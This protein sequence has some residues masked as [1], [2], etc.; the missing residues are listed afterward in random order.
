[1]VKKKIG[2]LLFILSKCEKL[3]T[4]LEIRKGGFVISHYPTN[5]K[6]K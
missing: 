6:G 3:S 5:R 4:Y 2:K 1:M